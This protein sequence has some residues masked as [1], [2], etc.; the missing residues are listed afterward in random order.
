MKKL[1]F[2]TFTIFCSKFV[3]SQNFDMTPIAVVIDE[4]NINYNFSI[5]PILENK[6]VNAVTESGMSA[7][8][9][10]RFIV[11]PKIAIIDKS[12]IKG[13]PSNYL[14]EIS[15]TVYSADVEKKSVFSS[16]SFTSKGAGKTEDAAVINSIKEINFNSNK[17]QEFIKQTRSR[18]ADYYANNCESILLSSNSIAAKDYISAISELNM[19]PMSS[20]DCYKKAQ[21]KVEK[22]TLD[23]LEYNCNQSLQNA[24]NI[25]S[26][27]LNKT[28]AINAI[29]VL[30]NTRYTSNCQDEVNKLL[31]EITSKFKDDEE[32]SREVR[33]QQLLWEKEKEK[34]YLDSKEK[35]NMAIY[36]L[37]KTYYRN[38]PKTTYSTRFIFVR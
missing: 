35:Q 18:I 10:G 15:F 19:I 33:N 8:G 34:L 22:F 13:P 16:L 1:V 32:Y 7:V 28:A 9:N 11:T 29:N 20:E 31:L 23:Y 38:Q 21:L 30:R 27:G 17:F 24:R 4:E 36:D 2:L 5:K 6:L 3:V 25:W 14:V 12:V 37:M 26:T